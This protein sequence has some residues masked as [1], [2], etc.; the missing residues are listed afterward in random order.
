MLS[1]ESGE[2]PECK[3]ANQRSINRPDSQV[4]FLPGKSLEYEFEFPPALQLLQIS[5]ATC[6]RAAAVSYLSPGDTIDE[7]LQYVLCCSVSFPASFVWALA[8]DGVIAETDFLVKV[9]YYHTR[10]VT[11]SGY[12]PF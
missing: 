10:A 12:C 1:I 3:R 4:S 6:I 2:I 8:T 11:S 9:C 7:Y 5:K